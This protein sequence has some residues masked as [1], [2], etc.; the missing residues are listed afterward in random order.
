MNTTIVVVSPAISFD[1]DFA[2]VQARLDELRRIK[3]EYT[4]RKRGKGPRDNDDWGNIPL[5]KPFRFDPES[6]R[7]DPIPPG[8]SLPR[9]E[10][11]TTEYGGQRIMNIYSML[12]NA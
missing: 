2:S 10:T 4:A 3:N 6:D 1:L 12:T 5:E 9:S 7:P 8:G 11:I